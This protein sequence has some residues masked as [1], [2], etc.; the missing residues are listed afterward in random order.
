DVS[1]IAD[2][3][4]ETAKKEI[5]RLRSLIK[6]VEC[7]V[8]DELEVIEEKQKKFEC[9]RAI[10]VMDSVMIDKEDGDAIIAPPITAIITRQESNDVIRMTRLL[11]E[12]KGKVFER[13]KNLQALFAQF[14]LDGSGY[15]SREEFRQ[16]MGVHGMEMTDE[17][18]ELVNKTYPHKETA[19]DIDKGIGYLEFVSMLTGK[20]TYI[21]G[22]GEDSADDE[23]LFRLIMRGENC[24]ETPPQPR[25]GDDANSVANT[26]SETAT[27]WSNYEEAKEKRDREIELQKVFNRRVFE[28]F[29]NM[30][31]AFSEADSDKSGFIERNE[32]VAVLSSTMGIEASDREVDLL[33]QEFDANNDGKLAYTEFVKCLQYS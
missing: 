29:Y 17:E 21:P 7:D 1:D 26:K 5:A 10:D 15:I 6:K 12:I 2:G 4:W 13:T 16:A 3:D 28:S 32:L 30:K 22:T 19:G 24:E 14:D 33:V 11:N 25:G 8:L 9:N 20:L 27:L 18:F 31:A 23:D